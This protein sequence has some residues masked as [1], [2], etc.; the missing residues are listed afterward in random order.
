[1]TRRAFL[2]SG[3]VAVAAVAAWSFRLRASAFIICD[4]KRTR[5]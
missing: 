2:L 4:A 1:M 5:P 3:G